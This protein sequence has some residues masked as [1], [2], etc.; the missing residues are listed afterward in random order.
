[1]QR[2]GRVDRRRSSDV[3]QRLL[4]AHPHLRAG[5]ESVVYWNFLPPDELETLLHLYNRVNKKTLVISKAFGIEGRK[6]LHP[7]DDFDPVKE[8]NEQFEGEQTAA[9]KLALE[10]GRLVQQHPELVERLPD[11]PLKTFSGKAAPHPDTKAVF[12][13]FRIPRPDPG[14]R[15]PRSGEPLW[16]EAAGGTVWLL[17]GIDGNP[18]TAEPASIADV[19]RCV[20][21]TARRCTFDHAALS[22]LR[23]KA[24]T[25]LAK[26][27]LRALQAPVGVAPVLK[28]WMEIN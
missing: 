12:F 19:V 15:D 4:D 23:K 8:I 9:E 17:F 28:C 25:Y 11:E 18:L 20:P 1:M 5:R 3:E 13:C 24:E 27:H 10:Y 22:E 6:L 7:E 16:T 21:D 2:I 26:T 14:R